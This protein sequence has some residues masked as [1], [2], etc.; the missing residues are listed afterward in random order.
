MITFTIPMPPSVNSLT[1][2]K[3][4]KGRV[5]TDRYKTWINAAGWSINQQRPRKIKGRVEIELCFPEK[6]GSDCDNRC[7]AA[8]DLLVLHRIIEGDSNK[9]VRRIVLEWGDGKDCRVTIRA[10]AAVQNA[11][12]A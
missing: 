1:R 12:A 2:N 11:E 6:N 9:Y 10:A 5:K 8:L 3:P 4:G 7:K